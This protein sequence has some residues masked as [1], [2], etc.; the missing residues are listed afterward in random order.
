MEYISIKEAAEKWGCSLRNVQRYCSG[1]L[2]S[3]A[4]KWGRA[5]MIPSDAEKPK[6]NRNKDTAFVFDMPMPRKS[7]FLDMT[8]LYHTYGKADDCAKVLE[9]QPEAQM[10][11]R[12]ESAYSRGEIAEVEKYAKYFLQY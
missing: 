9:N 10:L 5:W 6:D 7:V 8:N 3:G 11:F 4:V 1:G 12:A 2:V